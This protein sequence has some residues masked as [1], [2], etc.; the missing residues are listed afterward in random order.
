LDPS[1]VD[2]LTVSVDCSRSEPASGAMIV[3]LETHAHD[4]GFVTTSWPL[5]GS[6]RTECPSLPLPNLMKSRGLKT[7]YRPWGC[8]ER[9]Q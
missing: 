1:Q 2:R 9:G 3:R 5:A 8:G 7:E 6:D 4:L